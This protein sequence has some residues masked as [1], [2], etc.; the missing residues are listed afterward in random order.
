MSKYD[1]MLSIRPTYCSLIMEGKK[2]AEL[3]K[4]APK[5]KPP[6]KCFIYCTMGKDKLRNIVKDGDELYGY[7]HKGKTQFY[8]MPEV[9]YLTAGKRGKIIG[10]FV[11]DEIAPITFQDGGGA[12][13]HYEGEIKNWRT[14]VSEKEGRAYCGATEKRGLW[15]WHI[16][17]L[18]IYDK[19]KELKQFQ[20]PNTYPARMIRQAP[21]SWIYAEEIS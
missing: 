10:E 15:A 13:L 16:S 21:Q 19:P 17:E 18:K 9:D 14:C 5:Q 3:R 1:V 4:S 7:I 8:K 12:T 20:I 2:T 6:F 11:C